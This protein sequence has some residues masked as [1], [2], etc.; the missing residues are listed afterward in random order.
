MRHLLEKLGNGTQISCTYEC[1]A[2]NKCLSMEENRTN[3]HF[4]LNPISSVCE[5]IV[6]HTVRVLVTFFR[7]QNMYYVV[8]CGGEQ[9]IYIVVVNKNKVLNWKEREKLI[10][11]MNY[12]I[13]IQFISNSGGYTS[14][15]PMSLMKYSHLH[16]FELMFLS[17]LFLH[18]GHGILFR[19]TDYR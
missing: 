11:Y 16:T 14:S 10:S 9:N 5:S 6:I 7:Q 12:K 2:A 1:G 17:F 13:P 3:S 18:L 4:I 19:Y 8:L 15:K